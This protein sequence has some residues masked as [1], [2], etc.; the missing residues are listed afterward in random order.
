[1]ARHTH[2]PFALRALDGYLKED[3]ITPAECFG[4][5]QFRMPSGCRLGP[6]TRSTSFSRWSVT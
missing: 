2:A 6:S 3:R 1:L 4:A 5:P